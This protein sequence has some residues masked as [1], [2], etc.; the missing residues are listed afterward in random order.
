LRE[1]EQEDDK[2]FRKK[3]KSVIQ[4]IESTKQVFGRV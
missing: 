2:I 4:L 3:L 1:T